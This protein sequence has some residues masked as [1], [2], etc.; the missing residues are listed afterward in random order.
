MMKTIRMK[1][2][3]Q[4]L[5]KITTISV[6][7]KEREK[8]KTA[9]SF[10]LKMFGSTLCCLCKFSNNQVSVNA[11]P[12]ESITGIGWSKKSLSL[13]SIQENRLKFGKM[14]QRKI[15]LANV[16]VHS[17]KK[18]IQRLLSKNVESLL[19]RSMKSKKLMVISILIPWIKKKMRSKV[20]VRPS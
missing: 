11:I 6:T 12:L 7:N 20:H 9:G 15:Y 16:L 8:L 13:M 19:N 17:R 18:M 10:L 1:I 5:R 4:K 2:T 14:A 3:H